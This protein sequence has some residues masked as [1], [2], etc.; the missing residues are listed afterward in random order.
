M[1]YYKKRLSIFI[2]DIF[3]NNFLLVLSLLLSRMKPDTTLRRVHISKL[4]VKRFNCVNK[5]HKNDRVPQKDTRENMV[6][7]FSHIIGEKK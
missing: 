2:S 5:G 1:H 7:N 4:V 3:W 6:S